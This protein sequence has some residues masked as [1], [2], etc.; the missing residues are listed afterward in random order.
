MYVSQFLRDAVVG[1]HFT[2]GHGGGRST[3]VDDRPRDEAPGVTKPSKNAEFGGYPWPDSFLLWLGLHA[4]FYVMENGFQI[5][6]AYALTVTFTPVYLWAFASEW[7][8]SNAFL[9]WLAL[10]VPTYIISMVEYFAISTMV[11]FLADSDIFPTSIRFSSHK[12]DQLRARKTD[13]EADQPQDD[14]GVSFDY[15]YRNYFRNHLLYTVRWSLPVA[16]GSVIWLPRFHLTHRNPL[17]MVPIKVQFAL[18]FADCVYY[19]V[20]YRTWLGTLDLMLSAF[21]M[22]SINVFLIEMMLGRLTLFEYILMINYVFEMV[23]VDHAGSELPFWSGCPFFPPLGY[24]MGFD[25]STALHEAHHNFNRYSYGLL[26]FAD[27]IAGT[28]MF[29]TEYPGHPEHPKGK[30][31]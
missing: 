27:W 11:D 13:T 15:S 26:G 8:N 23:C 19:C 28:R 21:S 31:F 12:R 29:P 18:I 6:L 25:K 17:W 20:H 9:Y 2:S 5:L 3:H 16:I 4:L 22:G 30:Q 10:S 7:V 24:L 1:R 14:V